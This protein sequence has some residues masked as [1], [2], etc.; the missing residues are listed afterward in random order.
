MICDI[1]G[2][3]VQEI[4]YFEKLTDTAYC[5]ECY[6]EYDAVRSNIEEDDYYD[7]RDLDLS[8]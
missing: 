3:E 1:C 2:R 6:E 8:T 5:Q 7:C 4:A